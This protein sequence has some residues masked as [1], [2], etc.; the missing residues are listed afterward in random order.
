MKFRLE[1]LS[2][3]LLSLSLLAYSHAGTG[4]SEPRSVR[5]QRLLAASALKAAPASTPKNAAAFTIDTTT[6][7]NRLLTRLTRDPVPPSVTLGT[8]TL[9]GERTQ[10]GLYQGFPPWPADRSRTASCSAR[11]T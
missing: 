10:S 8:M 9:F 5:Y 6:S 3:V 2:T 7:T 4:P 1:S 11:E